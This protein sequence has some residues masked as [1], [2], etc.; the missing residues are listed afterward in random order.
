VGIFNTN[1][2]KKEGVEKDLF[3]NYNFGAT[4]R[5]TNLLIAAMVVE[6]LEKVNLGL[7]HNVNDRTA[8]G[9]EYSLKLTKKPSPFSVQLGIT[10]KIDDQSNVKGKL[11]S[12]TGLASIAYQVKVKP[13]VT[14]T[15]SLET[16]A[17]EISNGKVGFELSFEP[18][19]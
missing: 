2:L 13:D 9:F 5:T 10:H 16:S 14:A 11:L 19:Q 6:K 1:F 4:Y 17:K 3:K 15:I 7:V 8:V 18:S 12:D